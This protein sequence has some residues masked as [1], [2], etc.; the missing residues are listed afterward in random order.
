MYHGRQ[1]SFLPST[2]QCTRYFF[3]AAHQVKT[4]A[5]GI[6][7][8]NPLAE[9]LIAPLL[10]TLHVSFPYLLHSKLKELLPHTYFYSSLFS[11]LQSIGDHFY[12]SCF[13]FEIDHDHGTAMH[14]ILNHLNTVYEPYINRHLI[15]R[16]IGRSQRQILFAL[17]RL[18]F[19]V[20]SPILRPLYKLTQ[21]TV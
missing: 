19:L 8:D 21:C 1:R 2:E 13:L 14:F 17:F 6:S 15:Y 9:L 12:T 11:I 3:N 5:I 16:Y 10:F 4:I 18:Y 7:K 20:L